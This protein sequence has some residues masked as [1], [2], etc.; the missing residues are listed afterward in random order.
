MKTKQTYD[1]VCFTDLA[2]EYNNA[3][4]T[5]KKIKRRLKYHQLGKYDQERVDYL[6]LLK[7][8]LAAV[9]S[10]GPASGYYDKTKTT[11]FADISDF[12]ITRMHTDYC[13]AYDRIDPEEMNDLLYFSA[14]LFHTR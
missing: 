7:N 10:S 13:K 9:F 1:Y 6:R 3:K 2:Y 8:D 14:Y 12:N 11:G 5:E 4:E